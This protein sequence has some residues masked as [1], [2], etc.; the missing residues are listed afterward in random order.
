MHAGTAETLRIGDLRFRVDPEW[1]ES[2]ITLGFSE[3]FSNLADLT[4]TVLRLYLEG[5]AKG[6][7]EKIFRVFLDSIVD[8]ELKV[9]MM[10][11]FAKPGI[12][13]LFFS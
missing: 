12:K 13:F 1:L 3:N 4:D 5:K 6:K 11:T 2:D 8:K 10:L 9:S 7:K